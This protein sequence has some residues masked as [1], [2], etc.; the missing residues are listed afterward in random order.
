MRCRQRF[1]LRG[2]RLN[3]RW[4]GTGRQALCHGDSAG[5]LRD[6]HDA[7]VIELRRD[8]QVHSLPALD[9][10]LAPGDTITL[11]ADID[12]DGTMDF[13]SSNADS[14][15][16]SLRLGNGTT[17]TGNTTQDYAV[18]MGPFSVAAGDFNRDGTVDVVTANINGNDL[19][20]LLR[21]CK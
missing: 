10:A 1:R 20:V 17:F 18:G 4:E 12:G 7:L 3:G 15:N 6:Q 11:L 9:L 14:N 8:G 21:Q 2:A 16:V 5:E 13:I 19:S